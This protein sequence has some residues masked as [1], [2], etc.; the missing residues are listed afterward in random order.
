[1]K[2]L[3]D[4]SKLSDKELVKVLKRHNIGLTADEARQVAEVLGRTPTLT[5]AVLWGIQGSEHC[6]YKSSRRYLSQ[7]PTKA[8]NVILGPGE[9]AGIVEIAKIKGDKY[10]LIVGHE[11]HNH[12]SQIVPY[13]GAATGIGGCVRDIACMGGKVVAVMDPLRFGNIKKNEARQITHG[14]VEGIGGYGNPIGVPNL[15]GDAYFDDKYNENCLV[16][17]VAAGVV[18]KSQIIHSY[19]PKSAAK[20]QW[21]IIIVG[22][23]TDNSGMGGAAFASG[24]LEESEKEKN[25]GAVQEPNPFLKRHLLISTYD[26]FDILHKKKLIKKVSFKDMGAGGVTCSTVEQVAKS[27]LGAQIDLGKV[28]VAIEDMPPSV[29]GCAE[30]QERFTWMCH[31]SLTKMI[32]EH[33]NKKWDLPSV[34]DNAGAFVIGKV[35]EGNYQLSYRGEVYVDATSESITDALSYKRPLVGPKKKLKE[36]KVGEPRSY[37]KAILDLLG[38]ENIASKKPFYEKYDKQVQGYTIIEA[39]LADAGVIAPLMDERVSAD[40]KKIGI[41]LSTD[42]NPRHGLIDPYQAAINAV[43]ESMRNVAAVGAYPQAITNCLNYGNPEKKEQMWE[44]YEG[45]R[46]IAKACNEI[47]LKN[48]KKHPTP[49]IS[50]NVSLYNETKKGHIPPSAIICCIGKIDDYNK[51]I[52]MEL[53]AAGSTLYMLGT[54]K[55]ELGGSEYYRRKKELGANI[56]TVDFKQVQGEIY[57]VTDAVDKGLIT[58]AHDISEGG[59]AVTLAEMSFGGWGEGR[60]GID[61]DLEKVP[62]KGLRADKKLFSESGGFVVEVPVENQKKFEAICKKNGV[63]PYQIGETTKK[64]HIVF[65]NKDKVLADIK[66]EKAAETW[67]NGLRNKL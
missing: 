19:V 24:A 55:D 48:H 58:A 49:V 14:V 11:S 15:G 12:P 53:K 62:Q 44:L 37:K 8:P 29:I 17:V 33:Y 2:Y 18:K 36:P 51:A 13:E 4:F 3:P 64:S 7:L 25:K 60:F 35:K 47:K 5:E 30:T 50:G 67:L 40:I 65:R 1:M 45:I 54:R 57:S 41:A 42:G 27:G 52:T 59:L 9:D 34:A 31:P 23:P 39:G 21:D 38:S 10:G 43:V 26:L 28:N 22:K 63:T 66:V 32:V 16:N 46:G 56:P 20:E 6:S 61:V